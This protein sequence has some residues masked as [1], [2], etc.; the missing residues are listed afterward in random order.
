[1]LEDLH[2]A[3]TLLR[4]SAA[5]DVRAERILRVSR[6]SWKSKVFGGSGGTVLVAG[7]RC[8]F[9]GKDAGSVNS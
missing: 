9:G 7:V 3:L 8:S 2:L 6:A 4:L 1:L 5:A